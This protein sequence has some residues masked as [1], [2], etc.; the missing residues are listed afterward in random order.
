MNY[1]ISELGKIYIAALKYN[2]RAFQET[3]KSLLLKSVSTFLKL[4]SAI[5][6]YLDRNTS[7]CNFKL[8]KASKTFIIAPCLSNFDSELFIS[9]YVLG[10]AKKSLDIW[11]Y[12]N[13]LYTFATLST[14]A[15]TFVPLPDIPLASCTKLCSRSKS[16]QSHVKSSKNATHHIRALQ[17]TWN[18]KIWAAHPFQ[19]SWLLLLC[20][21]AA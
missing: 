17:H 11:Y 2:W 3:I 4:Y 9:F 10:T 6:L 13:S 1:S 8:S 16:K 5:F 7:G 19:F 18:A 15:K 21:T 14:A 12:V 20:F